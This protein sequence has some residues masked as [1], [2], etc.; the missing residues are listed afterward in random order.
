MAAMTAPKQMPRMIATLILFLLASIATLSN[1]AHAIAASAQA[2][3]IIKLIRPDEGKV[4]VVG[5]DLMTLINDSHL[6]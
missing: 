1:P 6:K 4:L 2:G 3:Q 5:K